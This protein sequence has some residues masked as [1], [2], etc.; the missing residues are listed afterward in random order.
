MPDDTLPDI[1]DAWVTAA[2][3]ADIAGHRPSRATVWQSP[4]RAQVRRIVAAVW[5]F[6]EAQVREEVASV[7]EGCGVPGI[8]RRACEEAAAKVRAGKVQERSDEEPGTP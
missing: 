4:S 2:L 1:P 8:E 7:V 3:R 5:P 6:I